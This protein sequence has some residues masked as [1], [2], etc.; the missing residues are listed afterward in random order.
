M[1]TLLAVLLN[2]AFAFLVQ[3]RGMLPPPTYQQMFDQ[4]DL[5]AIAE[6]I[7]TNDT[8][9][10]CL[11]PNIF[12]DIQV[13]GVETEFVVQ[14]MLKGDKSAT[15][16]FVL[17]HYREVKPI[18]RRNGPWLIAFKPTDAESFLLFLKKET[19]GRFAPIYN[20]TD[21]GRCGFVP[22]HIIDLIVIA[23]PV[24]PKEQTEATTLPNTTPRVHLAGFETEFAV[25][26]VL[27]G[28]KSEK[29]FVL[30]HYEE[31]RRD[32]WNSS[33]PYPFRIEFKP[34]RD[35]LY[36]LILKKEA[37][38]RFAPIGHPGISVIRLASAPQ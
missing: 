7:S 20:Q 10:R 28:D 21:P 35:H 26:E 13:I 32:G 16:K 38:G 15:K 18:A 23:Q 34:E 31:V 22:E 1:R 25:H 12:P 27:K 17:H 9:E 29:K 3:G 8:T 14:T 36:L 5:V 4:A 6:P 37:E 30:H 2:C 33:T 24:S 19:D 11:L